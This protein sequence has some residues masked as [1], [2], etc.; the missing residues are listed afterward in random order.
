MVPEDANP[1]FGWD[2][3]DVQNSGIKHGASPEDILGCL[4]FHVKDELREFAKR[5]K[6]LRIDIHVTS[7]DAGI[8]SK[9]ITI[10]ALKAFEDASF[11]RIL[12]SNLA[13][14]VGLRSCISDWGPLLNRENKFASI[15][16]QSKAWHTHQP[17]ATAQW[18]PHAMKVLMEK[19]SKIP[20]LVSAL[21]FLHA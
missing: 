8:L 4:F 21:D 2:V 3:A 10:G 19:C 5:V 9:G 15:L 18:G 1:L 13:D 16:M 14:S 17:H 11:D 12:T 7:F 6:E 20:G